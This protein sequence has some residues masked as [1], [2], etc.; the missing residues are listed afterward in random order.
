MGKRGGIPK[1]T[2]GEGKRRKKNMQLIVRN[3]LHGRLSQ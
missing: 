3:H 1:E 2:Q